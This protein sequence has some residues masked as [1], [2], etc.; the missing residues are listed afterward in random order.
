MTEAPDNCVSTIFGLI[1]V[2]TSATFTM[3][4]TFTRPVSVSTSTSTPVAPTIQNGVAFS[5]W[6]FW[7]GGV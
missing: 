5:V 6:P 7:S 1:G 3:R 4:V 2:P